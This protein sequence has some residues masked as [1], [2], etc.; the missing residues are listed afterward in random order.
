MNNTKLRRPIPQVVAL[1]LPDRQARDRVPSTL[2][3]AMALAVSL[4]LWAAMVLQP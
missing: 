1:V 3:L 4:S 2:V